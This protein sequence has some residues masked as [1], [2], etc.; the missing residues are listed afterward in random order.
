MVTLFSSLITSSSM[1]LLVEGWMIVAMALLGVLAYRKYEAWQLAR[2]R[3]LALAVEQ[4]LTA[5]RMHVYSLL[6]DV[7]V[8]NQEL[9]RLAESACRS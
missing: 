8:A 4:S 9:T 7:Y 6:T 5:I 3:V 1:S 2:R